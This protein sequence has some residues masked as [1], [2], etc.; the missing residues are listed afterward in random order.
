MKALLLILTAP[1]LFSGCASVLP[2]ADKGVQAQ[3]AAAQA[4]Y[5]ANGPGYWADSGRTEVITMTGMQITPI[6]GADPDKATLSLYVPRDYKQPI[7]YQPQGG[8]AFRFMDFLEK[9]APWAFGYLALDSVK[10]SGETKVVQE[11]SASGAGFATA[12]ILPVAT[13]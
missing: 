13:P 2:S 3:L 12:P 5:L 11:N 9:A 10:G 7:Q 1:L 6:P 8:T 4:F